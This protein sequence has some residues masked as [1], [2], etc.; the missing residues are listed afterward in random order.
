MSHHTS[1]DDDRSIEEND[2]QP[3][4]KLEEVNVS[5]D[6]QVDRD[7]SLGGGQRQSELELE[8][9]RKLLR[10]RYE[11]AR[12]LSMSRYESDIKDV[13]VAFT[14]DYFSNYKDVI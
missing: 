6:I 14:I 5:H 12:R 3:A 1:S 2:R 8:K 13:S 11:L 10:L 9:R 7:R 4:I